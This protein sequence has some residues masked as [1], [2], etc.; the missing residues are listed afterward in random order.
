VESVT[1]GGTVSHLEITGKFPLTEPLRET[2]YFVPAVLAPALRQEVLGLAGAALAA[3]GV[4]TGMTHTEVKLTPAGPRVIEV[5]GRLGGYV[6]DIVRRARG[7]DLVR[8]ALA[9]S[10]GLPPGPARPGYARH[11][12]QYFLLPPAGAVRLRRMAGVPELRRVPGIQLVEMFAT[13]GDAV[14]WR[15]GTLSYLGIVHGSAHSHAG[16]LHLAGLVEELFAA[17]YE[18]GTMVI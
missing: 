2:G 11:A 10:L 14:D 17:E 7:L 4:T 9:E 18:T 16:I 6:A 13:P 3:L 12:F 1:S 15:D 5:N 8:V